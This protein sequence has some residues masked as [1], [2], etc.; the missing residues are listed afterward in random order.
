MWLDSTLMAVEDMEQTPLPND[1][2]YYLC[3]RLNYLFIFEFDVRPQ[4]QSVDTNELN[5]KEENI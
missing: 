4:M 5:I 2:I 1:P 3:F